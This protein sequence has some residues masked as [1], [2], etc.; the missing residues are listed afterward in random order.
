MFDDLHPLSAATAI[1]PYPYYAHLV[2][3]RPFYRDDALAMWVASSASAVEEALSS[4]ALH[5][6]PSG[7]PVPASLAGTQLGAV[8]ARLA[9]MT[10]ASVHAA[11]RRALLAALWSV[12]RAD[13]TAAV[14]R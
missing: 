10:D 5:V 6:R 13:I 12:S 1:D 11:A 4:D 14:A 2:A 8:F 3:T 9:R 7:E